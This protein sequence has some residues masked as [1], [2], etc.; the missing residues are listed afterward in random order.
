MK[1]IGIII[2]L[3]GACYLSPAQRLTLKQAIGL[4]L[5]NN[6]DVNKADLASQQARIVLQQSRLSLLPAFLGSA[7]YGINSG[8]TNDP[9]TNAFVNQTT[10]AG[11]YELQGSLPLFNALSRQNT[12]KSNALAYDASKMEWQQSKDQITIN[13]ILAYLNVLSAEDL[14]SNAK[15]QAEGTRKESD[16]DSVK[17][18]SGA[19][20]PSDFYDLRGQLA[21]DLLTISDSRTNVTTA[22]IQ[23]AQ[24]LNIPYSDSLEVERL[25]DAA[26]QVVP[27]ADPAN[28]YDTALRQF[29]EV[30]AVHFRT[31]SADRNVRALRGQLYPSLS[32]VGDVSSYY[33]SAL[34][35]STL[36]SSQE[37][38]ST[39][40]VVI[41][42]SQY[43]VMTKQYE[44]NT[45]KVPFGSQ[46]H[47]NLSKYLG[48]SLTVPIFNGAQARSR[49]RNAQVLYRASQLVE[50]NTRTLLQQSIQQAYVNFLNTSDKYKI[51]L[52][53]VDAYTQS[54]N[55]EQARFESG[56][57]TA[58]LFLI[59]KNKLD[60][61]RTN[62]IATRYDYVLRAKILDYYMGKSLW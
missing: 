30:K 47:N 43:S 14:L 1:S 15:L 6:I 24:L 33:S 28:I 48:L 46:L 56:V 40:Y 44:Y 37:V 59:A 50:N 8:R 12:I 9:V 39:D 60:A 34:T 41:N 7:G 31:E 36:L 51:L 45:Q 61:A 5:T 3:V 38:P 27:V 58:D 29:A 62:L 42:G 11:S 32:L 25:S 54:F 22:K 23:L 2:I 16:I 13:I 49:L 17:N 53:Q 19:I 52:D 26:F 4:G 18:E 35:N 55:A 21:G 20:A 10:N 57:I